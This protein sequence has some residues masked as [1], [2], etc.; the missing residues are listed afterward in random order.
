MNK[1]QIDLYAE[2]DWRYIFLNNID[3]RTYYYW[4]IMVGSFAISETLS[5]F[6]VLHIFKAL[7]ANADN[8]SKK[9]YKLQQQLIRVLIIQ[10]SYFLW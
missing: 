6:L 1:T 7:S 8:F 2:G 9:T 5:I 10:V 3:T 4:G